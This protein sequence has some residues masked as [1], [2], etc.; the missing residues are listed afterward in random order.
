MKTGSVAHALDTLERDLIIEETDWPKATVQAL[1]RRAGGY[2]SNGVRVKMNVRFPKGGP[3]EGVR[4]F[5]AIE[6]PYARRWGA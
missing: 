1:A 2:D 6:I 4:W 5:E 3:V